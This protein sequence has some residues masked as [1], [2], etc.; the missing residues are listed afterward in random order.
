MLGS[1]SAL[2]SGDQDALRSALLFGSVLGSILV[3]VGILWEAK[4][5]DGAT[6]TVFVGIVIEAV[7]TIFLFVTDE[8]IVGNS[9]PKLRLQA[10]AQRMLRKNRLRI[11]RSAT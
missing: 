6:A 5:L 10:N 7:C 2:L 8:R 1:F 11:A 3:G 9:N 4:K